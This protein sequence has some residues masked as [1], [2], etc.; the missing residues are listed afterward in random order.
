MITASKQI[1]H[2][3]K[4]KE[5]IRVSGGSQT[6]KDK[7]QVLLSYTKPRFQFANIGRG[8]EVVNEIR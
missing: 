3:W 7:Q 4:I 1:L 8:V 2:Y 6:Q 5:N